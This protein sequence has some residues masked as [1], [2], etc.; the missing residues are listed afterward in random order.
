LR[1]LGG[2]WLGGL[3]LALV[4]AYPCVKADGMG[5]P[6]SIGVEDDQVDFSEDLQLVY[7]EANQTHQRTELFI[8]VK[9]FDTEGHNLTVAVPLLA[10]PLKVDGKRMATEDFRVR[11][12]LDGEGE[13]SLER[14]LSSGIENTA[15]YFR[16]FRART[17]PGLFI[18]L[19]SLV[20]ITD[21]IRGYYRGDMTWG[22]GT[23]GEGEALPSVELVQSYSFEGVSMHVYRYDNYHSLEALL[24]TLGL[25]IPDSAEEEVERYESHYISALTMQLIPPVDSGTLRYLEACC[26]D[27]VNEFLEWVVEKEDLLRYYRRDHGWDSNRT[28]MMVIDR[29]IDSAWDEVISGHT[30]IMAAANPP[31]RGELSDHLSRMIRCYLSYPEEGYRISFSQTHNG[32]IWYPLGTSSSW[33]HPIGLTEVL[34]KLDKGLWLEETNPSADAAFSSSGNAFY[35]LFQDANPKQDLS[36]QIS[37]QGLRPLWVMTK[38]SFAVVLN[39][40][41][42]LIA[43]GLDFSIHLLAWLVAIMVAMVAVPGG[44][45]DAGRRHLGELAFGLSSATYLFSVFPVLLAFPILYLRRK[46]GDGGEMDGENQTDLKLVRGTA[47]PLLLS[48]VAFAFFVLAFSI[49]YEVAL[50]LILFFLIAS[51][52]WLFLVAVVFAGPVYE[53]RGGGYRIRQWGLCILVA[54]MILLL[55]ALWA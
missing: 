7:I 25:V 43:F 35:W 54:C 29:F 5:F 18:P 24:G 8:A 55:Y 22:R 23:L 1:T 9:P 17:L 32:T 46:K 26:P 52:I 48:W 41:H 42:K 50:V 38:N 2:R 28:A 51:G 44:W 30:T 16:F 21:A 6:H 49:H 4:F 39:G 36:G 19:S 37:N 47:I 14:N 12:G 34:V 27:T 10:P 53:W 31:D 13:R 11:F 15:A 3:L 40:N 20:S 45:R 33:N